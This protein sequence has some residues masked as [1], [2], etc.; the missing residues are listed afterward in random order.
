[1]ICCQLCNKIV[2]PGIHIKATTD[3]KQANQNCKTCHNQKTVG[4][5][6]LAVAAARK[7]KTRT[8]VL[9]TRLKCVRILCIIVHEGEMKCFPE[10]ENLSACMHTTYTNQELNESSPPTKHICFSLRTERK[11]LFSYLP[12]LRIII[13]IKKIMTAE[14]VCI[15]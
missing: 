1:M 14:I 2:N 7:R 9:Q 15:Q 11:L 12:F 8:L 6:I 4:G 10:D 13:A 3:G 5:R